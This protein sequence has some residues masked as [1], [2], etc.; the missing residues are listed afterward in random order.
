MIKLPCEIISLSTKHNFSKGKIEYVVELS[1][2]DHVV[3]CEVDEEF[4]NKLD[5][6]VAQKPQQQAQ[7][8]QPL[9]VARKQAPQ[10]QANPNRLKAYQA[11][12]AEY[13]QQKYQQRQA[14]VQEEDYSIGYVDD[15]PYE[16]YTDEEIEQL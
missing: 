4:V 14:P 9:A 13:K 16:D 10:Q 11:K 2:L 3:Q 5:Q 12:I 1:V 6:S 7:A 15:K 8:P